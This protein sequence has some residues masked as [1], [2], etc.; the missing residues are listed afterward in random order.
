MRTTSHHPGTVFVPAKASPEGPVT[1]SPSL[2]ICPAGGKYSINPIDE[3][4]TCSVPGHKS[5]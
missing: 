2:A 1:V 4:P 3:P 5:P